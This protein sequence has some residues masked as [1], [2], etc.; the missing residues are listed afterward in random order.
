MNIYNNHLIQISNQYLL[1]H[2]SLGCNSNLTLTSLKPKSL[3]NKLALLKGRPE[4]S[5]HLGPVFQ[6]VVN[7]NQV[8]TLC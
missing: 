3:D 8:L 5:N 2:I 1:I 6:K 7:S 4:V